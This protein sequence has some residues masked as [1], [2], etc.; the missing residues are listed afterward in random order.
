MK[1]PGIERAG[2]FTRPL[3]VITGSDSYCIKERL[4]SLSQ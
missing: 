4:D 2:G 1:F 3:L